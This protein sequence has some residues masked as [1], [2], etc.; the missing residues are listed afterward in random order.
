MRLDIAGSQDGEVFDVVVVAAPQTSDKNPLKFFG[1]EK[2]FSFPGKFHQTVA[3]MVKGEVR[4]EYFGLNPKTSPT[5]FIVDRDSNVNSVS[6]EYPVDYTIGDE[7]IWTT[8][9]Y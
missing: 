7:G 8:K 4:E 9:N 5:L 3:T 1:F 6:K 2:A